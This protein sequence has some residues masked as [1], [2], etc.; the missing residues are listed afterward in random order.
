MLPQQ[1]T[2]DVLRPR[3]VDPHVEL[4][5]SQNGS[6]NLWFGSLVGTHGV[7]D[8]VDRHLEDDSR[9]MRECLAGFL[10]YQNVAALIGSALLADAVR[11]LALVAVRALREAGWGQEVVAAALGS[12]LLG[13]APFRIRHCSI[14]FSRARRPCSGRGRRCIKSCLVLEL[15]LAGDIRKRIPARIRGSLATGT[16]CGV[17]VL[18]TARAKPFTVRVAESSGGQ[19]EQHLLAHYV[20]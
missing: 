7:Y 18:A 19:G 15:E 10:G 4:A 12:P 5:S 17:Q 14:P 20:L 9:A 6:A 3:Q 13:V 11:K 8:D 2:Q 16:G 1:R